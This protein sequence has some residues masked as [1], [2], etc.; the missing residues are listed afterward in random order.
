[1][2]FIFFLQIIQF[3]SQPLISFLGPSI[4]SI[5]LLS[6]NSSSLFAQI[7]AFMN[8]VHAYNEPIP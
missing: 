3:G 6:L 2:Q 7:Y 1:V 5:G 4:L 8:T